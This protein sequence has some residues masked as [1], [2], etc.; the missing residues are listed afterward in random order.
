MSDGRWQLRALNLVGGGLAALGLATL[1][2]LVLLRTDRTSVAIGELSEDVRVGRQRL[3]LVRGELQ[4]HRS[5]VRL[6]RGQ[7]AD[8]GELPASPRVEEYF[9]A[10]SALAA[11]N[12]LRLLRQNPLASRSYPGLLERRY[13]YDLTGSSE[14][15]VRFLKA[16][17]AS[18]FWA[19][20]SYLAIEQG[21]GG[22]G[23]SGDGTRLARL[24][25]S[26]FSAP[27]PHDEG[28]PG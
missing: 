27:S 4:E 18:D 22:P 6:R 11:D 1:L 16:I 26:L 19:D 25:I 14:D 23:G 3:A 17:E 28:E 21:P 24:T 8:A 12:S 5:V 9:Q 13:A 20:V 7:L 15:L 10:L 2:W